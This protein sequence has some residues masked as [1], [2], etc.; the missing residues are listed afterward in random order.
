MSEEII[1]KNYNGL[2]VVRAKN[3]NFNAGFDGNPRTLPS[4]QIFATDKALKY[5]V[6]EFQ[7]LIGENVFVRRNRHIKKGKGDLNTFS[8]QTLEENFLNK[9]MNLKNQNKFE[10]VDE[11]KIL[12][13]DSAEK[14]IEILKSFIDIRLFGVVFAQGNANISL[15]GPVQISYGLNKLNISNSFTS[16]ILSPYKN[17]NGKSVDSN[18]TTIGEETRADEIY[19]V[20]NISVNCENAKETGMTNNDLESLKETLFKSVDTITSCTKYGCENVALFWIENEKNLVFNN[21][22]DFVNIE[23]NKETKKV[24][25]KVKEL[26]KEL[27]NYGYEGTLKKEEFT[28]ETKFN[29]ELNKKIEII[30][31][32][33]KVEIIEE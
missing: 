31:K 29:D 15:T 30:Y 3:A 9:L 24:E 19:Y 16:Q 11:S 5:C 13:E 18:Q 32:K 2:L 6:R 21:L 20:Y 14:V 12:K 33:N 4:G 27:K 26:I 23:I 22:D 25:I 10:D 8:Y 1:N 7:N 28:Q 17:P